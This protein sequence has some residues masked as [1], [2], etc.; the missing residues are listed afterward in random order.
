[1]QVKVMILWGGG[2]V[3]HP[4]RGSSVNCILGFVALNL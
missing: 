3:P 4:P 2:L 1:M